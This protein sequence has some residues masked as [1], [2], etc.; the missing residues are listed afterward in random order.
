M[1]C[2]AANLLYNRGWGK[3]LEEKIDIEPE[4]K[5]IIGL[6]SGEMYDCADLRELTACVVGHDFLENQYAE[7]DL[8]MRLAAARKLGLQRM[9]MNE[10]EAGHELPEDV[11]VYDE[12]MGKFPY[13]LTDTHV[14]YDIHVPEDQLTIIRIET[15]KSFLYTLEKGQFIAVW[16]KNEETGEYERWLNHLDLDAL[17]EEEAA[18]MRQY[19]SKER[20]PLFKKLGE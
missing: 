19:G 7:T 11:I 12:R 14:D 10:L 9:M 20:P 6:L 16:E 18:Y 5:Y 15:N 8:H 13:S 1:Q 3:I 4:Q 2:E 17:I